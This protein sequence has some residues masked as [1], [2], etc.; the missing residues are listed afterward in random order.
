[1]RNTRR[2]RHLILWLLLLATAGCSTGGSAEP[3]PTFIPTPVAP[4]VQEYT[5]QRGDV[6]RALE[7]TGRLRPVNSASLYFE[8]DGRVHD[9][10]V[11]RDDW[12]EAGT[13]LAQLDV[14]ELLDQLE[15]AELALEAAQ[16]SHERALAL[17]RINLEEANLRLSSAQVQAPAPSVTIARVNLDRATA[18][19]NSAQEEYDKAADRPWE[20]AAVLEAY[21]RALQQ[22]QWNCETAQAQYDLAVQS[23]HTYSYDVALLEQE[24]TRAEL[25]LLWLEEGAAQQL[26]D[27]QSAQLA[28][29]R[30]QTQIDRARLVAPFDGQVISFA[31]QPGSQVR[32]FQ[33]VAVVGDPVE[34]EVTAQ[35][36]EKQIRDVVV[37][38]P[39]TAERANAPGQPIPAEV[40]QLPR[41]TGP[42]EDQDPGIHIRLLETEDTTLGID[43]VM[44]VTILVEEA[45]D[46]LWLPPQAIRTFEGRRYVV[47][48]DGT[49]QYRV[50]VAIGV[51][52]EERVEI[53]AGLEEGQ[54]V[55]SP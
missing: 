53:Q 43:E 24:V 31:T 35:L 37:G 14:E 7:F 41:T 22:A 5:V 39:A 29:E 55:V 10:F 16:K 27:V 44:R 54:V 45:H 42:V 52:G 21:D 6:A 8:V 33:P 38:M 30:L 40:R 18:A 23:S 46:V 25:E 32:A 28:V 48:R 34:L 50:D 13:V 26:Q 51:E 49:R 11:E 3:T 20:P 1:M 36:D 9:V 12:V 47:V 15:Q 4:E 17:A 2:L 19:L